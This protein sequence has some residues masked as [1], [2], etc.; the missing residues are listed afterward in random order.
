MKKHEF[1]LYMNL[2]QYLNEALNSL[3]DHQFSNKE[4]VLYS[5]IQTKVTNLYRT[6]I[7]KLNCVKN[8][9]KRLKNMNYID[10]SV[11][12]IF[13]DVFAN[14]ITTF[15]EYSQWYTDFISELLCFNKMCSDDLNTIVAQSLILTFGLVIENFVVNNECYLIINNNMQLSRNRLNMIFGTILADLLF[16]FNY[17][18]KR[19]NFSEEEMA[20]FH[21]LIVCFCNVNLIKEKNRFQKTKQRYLR[22]FILQLNLKNRDKAFYSLLND[23]SRF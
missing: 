15:Y 6:Q 3:N 23:V 13:H 1:S 22:A 8:T 20:L 11:E 19:I 17:C 12:S 14:M 7:K 10:S 16:E 21:T 5:S 4:Y 2:T 9:Q 18:L